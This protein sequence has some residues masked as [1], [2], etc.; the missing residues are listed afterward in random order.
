MLARRA[1]IGGDWKKKQKIRERKKRAGDGRGYGSSAA[2]K[3]KGK[4]M[5]EKLHSDGKER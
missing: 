2:G 1:L 3:L 4:L 5:A